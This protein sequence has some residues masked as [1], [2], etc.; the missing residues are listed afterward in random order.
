MRCE[1]IFH[2]VNSGR[3]AFYWTTKTTWNYHRSNLI[4][5]A[6]AAK[7]YIVTVDNSYPETLHS[8]SPS[9]F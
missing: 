6:S 4:I 7:L 8:S 3:F 2:G 5:R 9:V 1:I